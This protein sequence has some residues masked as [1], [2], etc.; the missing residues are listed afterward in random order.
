M[1][2]RVNHAGKN[3]TLAKIKRS[4]PKQRTHGGNM[5]NGFIFNSDFSEDDAVFQYE[6]APHN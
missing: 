4:R 1:H 2:M 3:I 6:M 5:M